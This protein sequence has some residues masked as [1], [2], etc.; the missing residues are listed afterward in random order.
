M[1]G[2]KGGGNALC[3][4]KP[5]PTKWGGLG[6]ATNSTVFVFIFSVFSI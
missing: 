5:S 2:G 6:L 4:L 1:Y 3:A